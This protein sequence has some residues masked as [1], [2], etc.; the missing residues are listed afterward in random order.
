MQLT[1]IFWVLFWRRRK[2][3]IGLHWKI[4]TNNFGESIG[5]ICRVN[6]THVQRLGLPYIFNSPFCCIHIILSW[7]QQQYIGRTWWKIPVTDSRNGNDTVISVITSK[8]Q[9]LLLDLNWDRTD[10]LLLETAIADINKF[11]YSASKSTKTELQT[12]R[13]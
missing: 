4:D 3:I 7:E 10:I 13:V 6:V 8:F 2:Y 5:Y 1:T 12:I 11:I 9:K